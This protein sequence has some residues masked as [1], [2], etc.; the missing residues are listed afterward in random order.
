MKL[1]RSIIKDT[2]L[3]TLRIG[4]IVLALLLCFGCEP[5]V[6]P[7]HTFLIKKGEHY[8]T[9]RLVETLQ[10][11]RL[12]F[13]AKFDSSAQYLFDDKSMQTN[14]N[15]LLGFADCNEMHH[16]NSARFA[17]QWF[18]NRLEIFSY[19][20]NNGARVEQFLGTVSLNEYHHFELEVTPA[21]FIFKLNSQP[22]VFVEKANTCTQ[23][24]YYML[25]PYF[26]GTLPAP[27]DVRLKIKEIV[28]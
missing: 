16:Q 21:H 23:G 19:C 10:G 8:S 9:P 4:P 27:H 26:G 20:Y 15:K 11:T 1:S 6:E 7:E 12:I 5:A 28:I 3:S 13:S 24:V 2:S 17:W 18:N 22:P 14:K 25:W